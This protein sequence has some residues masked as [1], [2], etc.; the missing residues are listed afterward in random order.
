MEVEEQELP[1]SKNTRLVGRR[2][3]SFRASSMS[4]DEELS[5]SLSWA[6][7]HAA[8][9]LGLSVRSDGYVAVEDLLSCNHPRFDKFHYTFED[10]Q[11]VVEQNDK[12][13]FQLMLQGEIVD[14]VR[15]R[16]RWM[17][18][19]CQGHS[20][21]HIKPDEL[22]TPISREELKCMDRIIHGTTLK[23]WE[24]I[25]R[26]GCLR[27]MKRNHIHFAT[28]LPD[29]SSRNSKIISGIRRGREI[30]IYVDSS[31]CAES[32]IQFYRSNNEVI[33]TSGI[34]D[35][36]ILPLSFLAKVVEV[37]TGQI[38]YKNDESKRTE[39]CIGDQLLN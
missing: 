6:L 2:K 32:S 24:A 17:I 4:K 11:R 22:L 38:I 19:A 15:D 36:G 13:R 37:K 16:R 27:R 31:K 39:L 26:E 29:D 33:L 35:E 7:R 9:S 8:P 5:R 23:A 30:D 12:K 28:T 18:R 14:G 10:V 21:K 20:L 25:Q 3:R 1:M 34:R